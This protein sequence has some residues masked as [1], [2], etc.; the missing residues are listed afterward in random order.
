M[1]TKVN[2][3]IDKRSLEFLY[4]VYFGK[5]DDPYEAASNR[6]YR[7]MNRTIR[8]NGVDPEK[9]KELKA[10][11]T[12]LLKDSICAVL[13]ATNLNQTQ[14]DKWHEDLCLQ[15]IN[16]YKKGSVVLTCGQAQKWVN[17]TMKYLYVIDEKMMEPIFV[18]C[19]VPL[20]N[21]IFAYSEKYFGIKKPQKAWSRW[22]DYQKDYM[23]YQNAL[24]KKIENESPLGW[25]F[26]AW[27]KVS[28]E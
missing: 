28:K 15:I 5:Y 9:R 18:F 10:Q 2:V 20:D 21:Y 22:C 24:R 13:S 12:K 19:H 17:M 14:Y 26:A 6:A 7:D 1:K 23:A 16:C 4:A 8:F 3:S 27:V 11:V 25:E